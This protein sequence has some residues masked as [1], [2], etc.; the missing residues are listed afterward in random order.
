MLRP[1]SLSARKAAT[2]G[3]CSLEKRVQ[4]AVRAARAVWRVSSKQLSVTIQQVR[5]GAVQHHLPPVRGRRPHPLHI[6][7]R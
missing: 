7:I 3:Y 5:G 1:A 6:I 4:G 2:Q